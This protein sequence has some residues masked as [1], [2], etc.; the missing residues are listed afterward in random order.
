M[1]NF[2]LWRINRKIKKLQK[3]QDNINEKLSKLKI[4]KG[5]IKIE[6]DVMELSKIKNERVKQKD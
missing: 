3:K 4:L 2:K 1:M 5:K 6:I